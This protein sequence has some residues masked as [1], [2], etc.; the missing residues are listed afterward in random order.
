[1]AVRSILAVGSI[2]TVFSVRSVLAVF[3]V[4]SVFAVGS[5]LAGSTVFAILTMIDG[6]LAAL[7]ESDFV[8]DLDIVLQNLADSC[9]VVV[10]LQSSHDGLKGSDVRIHVT[11]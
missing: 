1:M 6:H 9:H 11:A 4:D 8:T 3:S 7:A 5:V 2:F 10:A